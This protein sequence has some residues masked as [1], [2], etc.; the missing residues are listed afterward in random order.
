ML[1]RSL[2][3]IC[4]LVPLGALAYDFSDTVYLGGFVSQGYLNTA[5]HNYLTADAREGSG[6]F[7]EAALSVSAQPMDNLRV[8]M[9][10]LG[11]DFGAYGNTDVSVDWAYG[12]YRWRDQLGFRAGRIKMPWGLYNQA[13]DVDML[14][15]PV[16]LPQSVYSEND[17]DLLI[18]YEG[19]GVYGSFNL[20]AWGELDYELGY[21][22][23]SMPEEGLHHMVGEWDEGGRAAEGQVAAETAELYGL[24]PSSVTARFAELDDLELNVPWIAGGRVIWATP[25]DGLRLALS[26][27]VGDVEASG[28]YRYDVFVDQGEAIPAYLPARRTLDA[29]LDFKETH[30]TSLEYVRGGWTMAAE[31]STTDMGNETSLGWYVS[32]EYRFCSRWSVAGVFSEF[33]PDRQDR[34]GSEWVDAGELDHRA[35]QRDYC[36]SVRAD[37]NEHWLVKLEFHAMDGT[38]MVLEGGPDPSDATDRYWRMLAAKTTFHF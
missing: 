33:F 4:L 18:A 9:Q 19:L 24:D 11:R 27:F 10:L 37:I 23:L 15:V 35:W 1:R 2:M 14:R 26:G 13:R 5:D 34:D 16:L 32:N 31:V 20:D 7:T 30:T 36:L 25:V 3:A 12:D 8:G 6:K 21:G 17:R 29:D 28:Y 22:S 38:A